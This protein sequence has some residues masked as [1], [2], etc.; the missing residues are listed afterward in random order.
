M[1]RRK[2]FLAAANPGAYLVHRS[3]VAPVAFLLS[4]TFPP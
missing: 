2:K 4:W 3:K 1:L